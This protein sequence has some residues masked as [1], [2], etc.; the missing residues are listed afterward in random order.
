MWSELGKTLAGRR[1]LHLLELGRSPSRACGSENTC[2][3]S[4]TADA[5]AMG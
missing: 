3:H 1:S 4:E 5:A 2:L